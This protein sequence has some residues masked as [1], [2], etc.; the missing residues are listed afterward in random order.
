MLIQVYGRPMCGACEAVCN[1]LDQQGVIYDYTDVDN[2]TY[3]DLS[4]VL[5]NRNDKTNRLLPVIMVD[6]REIGDISELKRFFANTSRPT[7]ARVG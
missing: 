6:G 4:F 5:L 3:E 1:F 2:M 7:P